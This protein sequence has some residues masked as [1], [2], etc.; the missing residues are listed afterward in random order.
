MERG[1]K[2]S[3]TMAYGILCLHYGVSALEGQMRRSKFSNEEEGPDTDS[4]S[5]ERREFESRPSSQYCNKVTVWKSPIKKKYI[6]TCRYIFDWL[7]KWVKYFI[8]WWS[9]WLEYW[10]IE[11][12]VE[13]LIDWSI[14]WYKFLI[15]WAS[16]WLNIWLIE[17]VVWILI[18]WASGWIFDLLINWY[19]FLI[20]WASG[21]S[22]WMINRVV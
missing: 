15:D 13:Y 5:T 8:D 14:N 21:L 6:Y 9:E 1:V 22:I 18:D 7:S 2:A 20:H 4:S 17:R 10:L 12:V 3:T 19:T 11:R 16:K